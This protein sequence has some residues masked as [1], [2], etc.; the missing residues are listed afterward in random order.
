MEYRMLEHENAKAARECMLKPRP[1]D[2]Q[3]KCYKICSSFIFQHAAVSVYVLLRKVLA[4][5]SLVRELLGELGELLGVRAHAGNVHVL[6]S[7]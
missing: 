7:L 4:P 3:L 6:A 2:R 1:Y 5:A